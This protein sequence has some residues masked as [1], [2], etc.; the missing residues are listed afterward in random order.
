MGT[1][2]HPVDLLNITQRLIAC[3][4]VRTFD[5]RLSEELRNI[6]NCD[7]VGF[8]LY[9]GSTQSFAPVSEVLTDPQCPG[10][11]IGQLPSEGTMK[12]A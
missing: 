11:L 12:E 6:L 9:S 3:T 5:R 1:S 2:S 10:Y 4:T 7:L 8:Y